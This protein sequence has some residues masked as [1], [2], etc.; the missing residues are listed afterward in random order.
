M[1][2]PLSCVSLWRQGRTR[3]TRS[4]SGCRGKQLKATADRSAISLPNLSRSF[5]AKFYPCWCPTWAKAASRAD[6][7]WGRD[8]SH[9]LMNSFFN[10]L[11]KFW[12]WVSGLEFH[13]PWIWFRHSGRVCWTFLWMTKIWLHLIPSSTPTSTRSWPSPMSPSSTICW[14]NSN[15]RDS[16]IRQ[17]E[18]TSVTWYQLIFLFIHE[19]K[20]ISLTFLF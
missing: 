5:T 2:P 15:I 1:F 12:V 8:R 9:S 18:A 11:E 13:F 7:Q 4:L 14:K 19:R 16:H 10:T 17:S 20:I 3:T 6:L